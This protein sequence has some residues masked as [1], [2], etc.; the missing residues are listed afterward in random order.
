M[1]KGKCSP[2]NI[3]ALSM[4]DCFYI[5]SCPTNKMTLCEEEQK[6]GENL[7]NKDKLKTRLLLNN[8]IFNKAWFLHSSK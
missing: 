6:S 3:H 1:F 5:H 7:T 4:F 8:V 2:S